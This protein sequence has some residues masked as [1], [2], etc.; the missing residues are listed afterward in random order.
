M[1][2]PRRVADINPGNSGSYPSYLTVFGD[3]LFFRASDG[4]S[5]PEL[6][7]TDGTAAGTVRVADIRPGSNIGSYPGELIAFSGALL[8]RANDGSSGSELW[9]TDGTSAGTMRV[10]DIRPGIYGS[11]PNQLTELGNTLFF[12]AAFT[13]K[14]ASGFS[15]D[16]LWKTDG[17]SAGTVLVKDIWLEF[18]STPRYLAAVGNNLFFS[19]IESSGGDELWKSDGTAEGTVRVADILPGKDGSQ[20]RRFAAIGNTLIFVANDGK[21]GFEL[22][23]TNGTAAGTVRASDINPGSAGSDPRNFTALGNTLF[24]TAD[25]GSSGTELWKTDGTTAGTVRVADINPGRASS[26][27]VALTVVGDSLYFTADSVGSGR[28]LW[29]TDGSAAGTVRV[30]DINPGNASSNPGYLAAVG[31][32]LYFNADSVGSGRELWKTD[33]SA[34][35]TVR[36]ADINP[37]S[38]Q[39]RAKYF[40]KVGDTLYFSAND[41]STGTELWALDLEES[42]PK[43]HL[44]FSGGGFNTHSFLA[45]LF[46][47][48]LDVMEERGSEPGS[49]LSDLMAN[50]EGIGAISGGSWFL[51]HL[52]YS[53]IFND[54]FDTRADRDAYTR[55]GYNGALKDAFASLSKQKLPRV[56]QQL[57]SAA[58]KVIGP[59]T[60]ADLLIKL[61]VLLGK[62]K[63]DW[64]DFVE[65]CV[66]GPLGMLPELKNQSLAASRQSWATSKDFVIATAIATGRTELHDVGLGVSFQADP[67]IPG[68]RARPLGLLSTARPGGGFRAT[69]DDPFGGMLSLNYLKP[70]PISPKS[71]TIQLPTIGGIPLS[72]KL[73][74]VDA[75]VASSSALGAASIFSV[76]PVNELNRYLNLLAPMATFRNGDRIEMNMPDTAP[77]TADVDAIYNNSIRNAEARL[78]DGGYVDNAPAAFKLRQIQAQEGTSDP[79]DLTLFFN[80][81]DDPLTGVSM[82]VAE[83]GSSLSSYRLPKDLTQL[84]GRTDN[85]ASAP[86]GALVDGPFP[87]PLDQ[88]PSPHIFR[89]EAWRGELEPDWQFQR[90]K[91]DIRYFDLNVTTVTNRQFGIIGGQR[92]RLRLFVSSNAD[93]FASPLTRSM[94]KQY[95][96]NYKFARQAIAGFGGAE[97]MLDALGVP[98][99]AGTGV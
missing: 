85:E 18:G 38:A 51:S 3:T 31:D 98:A 28:E 70:R 2:T 19:A 62:T 7:K 26:S 79:F 83:T 37:G 22:W 92:G 99:E 97:F 95:D 68:A 56:L 82:N 91:I 86:A 52:A 21:S 61:A 89:E 65:A 94:L 44:C 34:A 39:S 29:K 6:W 10:A 80:S 27:P 13:N 42:A 1:A 66:Y 47:G 54:Q 30:A 73:S 36:V 32:S 87:G 20:P 76:M 78:I 75:T 25:D 74:I 43:R 88:M 63:P 33:G 49:A 96:L 71:K 11:S 14:G 69:A 35:G 67:T 64:R 46:A 45:G 60:G 53:Q 59:N 4:S 16:E 8:F 72:P 55:S 48:A 9:K 12:A 50:V 5:G 23:R 57:V 41:G 17:T 81:S 93:S 58:E 77:S 90:D 24:F 84:F 40:T 15:F